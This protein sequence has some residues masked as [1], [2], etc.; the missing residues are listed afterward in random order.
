M[1]I[2]VTVTGVMNQA[3]SNLA[4]HGRHP[5]A[6]KEN[7]TPVKKPAEPRPGQG[8]GA[9]AH[10]EAPI[11]AAAP[12]GAARTGTRR[13]H[14]RRGRSERGAPGGRGRHGSRR[15]GRLGAVQVH[16]H[17]RHVRRPGLRQM[18]L[19]QPAR[20]RYLRMLPRR[21]PRSHLRTASG[22]RQA[23]AGVSPGSRH[24]CRHFMCKGATSTAN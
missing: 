12:R 4:L 17:A 10:R 16:R 18:P 8:A 22:V 9:A 5:V 3:V 21:A 6:G 24:V 2:P 11:A 7:K 23:R 13:P 14:R 19:L 1:H 15:P 20:K